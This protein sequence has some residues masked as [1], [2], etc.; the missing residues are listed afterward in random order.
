L[1]Q[2]YHKKLKSNK[3]IELKK[4][5]SNQKKPAWDIKEDDLLK[6]YYGQIAMKELRY[7]LDRSEAAIRSR[8]KRLRKKGWTFNTTRR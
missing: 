1:I 6:R 8:V 2:Y 3:G 4:K 7:I 5:R